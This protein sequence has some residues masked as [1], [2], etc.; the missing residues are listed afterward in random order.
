MG[1]VVMPIVVTMRMLVLQCLVRMN[2]AVAFG[3]IKTDA[4]EHHY[5]GAGEPERQIALA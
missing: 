5:R 1:M 3:G 4:D 2:L